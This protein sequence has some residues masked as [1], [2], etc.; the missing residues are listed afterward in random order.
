MSSSS[1]V[2][3]LIS[4]LNFFKEIV[5]PEDFYI[6]LYYFFRLFVIKIF[7]SIILWLSIRSLLFTINLFYFDITV[8]SKSVWNVFPLLL[9]AFI[10]VLI[11]S[12]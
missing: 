1:L 5:F 9:K 8:I 2:L 12:I 10:L 11:S 3:E 7:E 6:K 4:S